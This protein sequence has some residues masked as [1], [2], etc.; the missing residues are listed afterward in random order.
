MIEKD[1]YH[2]I[3]LSTKMSGVFITLH[4]ISF[5]VSD[6]RVTF[7]PEDYPTATIIDKRQNPQE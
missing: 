3:S 1:T 4:D 7:N 5:G 2:P 6:E